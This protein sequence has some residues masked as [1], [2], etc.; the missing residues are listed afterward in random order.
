MAGY[1]AEVTTDCGTY[2]GYLVAP[3]TICVCEAGVDGIVDVFHLN[4]NVLTSPGNL[5]QLTCE[6]L[7]ELRRGEEVRSARLSHHMRRQ[8]AEHVHIEAQCAK[9]CDDAWRHETRLAHRC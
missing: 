2:R 4:T 3:R 5:I 9:L 7:G 6:W 1:F 8:Q